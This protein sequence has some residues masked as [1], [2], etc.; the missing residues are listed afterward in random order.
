MDFLVIG[1]GLSGGVIA[2]Q[3]AEQGH[4]V[5]IWEKRKQ[6]GGNMYDY[7]DQYGILVHKYGPH[8]FHTKEKAL[9]DYMCRFENW[10]PY[11]L[12]CGAFIEG[13]FTPTPFNFQTID[14]YYEPQ[15]AQT[16]KEHLKEYFKGKTQV[17]VV[18]VLAAKDDLIR[19][20]GQFLF[21]Q[22][23][24]LYTA[25]QWGISA[26]AVDP[27]ILKRVPLRLSY[28]EGYFDD[29][30][31][32]MPKHSYT[33]FFQ[34]LLQHPNINVKLGI[35]AL[36]HLEISQDKVLLDGK[37]TDKIII[38]TGALD[39]LFKQ[40]LGPLPYRS[41]K[42]VWKHEAKASLQPYPVTAYPKAPG[43]TRITEYNKLPLQKTLGTTYAVEYPLLYQPGTVQ[44]PYYPLL[45][46]D[47]I[48][49]AQSYQARALKLQ[50]FY[51]CGRL[52]DFKYYNMDQA[53]KR[54][55]DLACE[56]G[57]ELDE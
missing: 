20:Y 47:S 12:T 2:R 1:A 49:K 14:D 18:E 46:K 39:E 57:R 27:S 10:E 37:A 9:Y 38:Y 48:K 40:S 31:Q 8:T 7:R 50:N 11:Q 41:L 30:Y 34:N 6:V 54:A 35:D 44:E 28:Q 43:Y 17:T 55:L 21:D 19:E 25:K 26:Q 13:K 3:L 16:L 52:A 51:F 42:F 29:S 24:S 22:D 56:I 33:T 5:T 15:K 36:D 53:L 32:V 4:Q 23:Y 45:T